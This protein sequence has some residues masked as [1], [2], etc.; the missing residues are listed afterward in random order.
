MQVSSLSFFWETDTLSI[1]LVNATE[2]LIYSSDEVTAG[3]LVDYSSNDEIVALDVAL[4]SKRIAAE[5]WDAGG[6][7]D[8]KPS[9]QLHTSFD[10]VQARF[11]ISFGA[12][13]PGVK[14]KTTDDERIT[15]SED[16]DGRW[17]GIVILIR[18]QTNTELTASR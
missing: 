8:G 9:L 17:T 5:F 7:H 10:P 1:Y 4:A 15:V 14:S 3:L 16:E 12:S 6:T 11:T 13:R 2:G 18:G